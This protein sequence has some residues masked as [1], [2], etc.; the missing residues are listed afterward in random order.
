MGQRNSTNNNNNSAEN[1]KTL[2]FDR[3]QRQRI[4]QSEISEEERKQFE[5][6]LSKWR[7]NESLEQLKHRRHTAYRCK[8]REIIRLN[9][10]PTWNKQFSDEKDYFK[11]NSILETKYK[12][13]YNIN[14]RVSIFKANIVHLEI[15]AIVNAANASLLGGGG[16][17]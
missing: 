9:R 15:D 11:A 2:E 14:S 16:G 13:N 3:E 7:Q 1:P 6:P 10:I 4:L 8:K 12:V 17:T 5:I